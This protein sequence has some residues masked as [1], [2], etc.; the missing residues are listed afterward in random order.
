MRDTFNIVSYSDKRAETTEIGSSAIA[1]GPRDALCQ[2]TS[3]Q[4]LH[5]CTKIRI[6]KVLQQANDLDDHPRSSQ[7]QLFDVSHIVPVSVAY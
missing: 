5:F 1:E 3:C 6:Y 4:L 7:F 2:V